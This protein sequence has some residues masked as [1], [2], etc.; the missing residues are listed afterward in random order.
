M[1]LFSYFNRLNARC[2]LKYVIGHLVNILDFYIMKIYYLC[3]K[4]VETCE[5]SPSL[6]SSS[7][8]Q[9]KRWFSFPV[10]LGRLAKDEH[11]FI[12]FPLLDYR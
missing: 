7:M 8:S 1:D 9:F 11:A 12:S 3:Y 5:P 4:Y 10:L 6:V 2:I